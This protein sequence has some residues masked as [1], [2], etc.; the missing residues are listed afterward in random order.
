V[1]PVRVL[2]RT[3]PQLPSCAGGAAEA[4]PSGPEQIDGY[5]STAPS[6][7][8]RQNDVGDSGSIVLIAD[9]LFGSPLLPP[10]DE[11]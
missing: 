3:P 2:W 11:R 5:V 6:V 1:T 7:R 9:H 10:H 4:P 8:P